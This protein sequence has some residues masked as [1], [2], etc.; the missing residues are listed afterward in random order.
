M[1]W[2]IATLHHP[3]NKRKSGLLVC[4]CVVFLTPQ[5]V[6]IHHTII[7]RKWTTRWLGSAADGSPARPM[8]K[9]EET[10]SLNAK[11]AGVLGAQPVGK[12]RG[13]ML[14]KRVLVKRINRMHMPF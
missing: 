1:N 7:L 4:A 2:R 12:G 11:V 13:R 8:A 10:C 9:R 14:I 6:I 5:R 3:Q